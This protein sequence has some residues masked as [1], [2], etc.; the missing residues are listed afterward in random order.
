M[1]ELP[2]QT[3]SYIFSLVSEFRDIVSNYHEISKRSKAERMMIRNRLQEI[4]KE[5]ETIK[6]EYKDD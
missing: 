4:K 5:L 3:K 6:E 2:E 1:K